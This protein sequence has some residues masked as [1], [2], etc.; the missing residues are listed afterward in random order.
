[1]IDREREAIRL[2]PFSDESFIVIGIGA[3]QAIVH[4]SH[5]ES[6]VVFP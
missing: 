4:V 6:K 3:T 2:Y 5:M 1:M